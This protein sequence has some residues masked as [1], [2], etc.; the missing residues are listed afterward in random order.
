MIVALDGTPVGLSSGGLRRY[1]EE[2]LRALQAAFPMNQHKLLSDQLTAP[3]NLLE[4][5]WWSVGL[6]CALWRMGADVF[7]GTDFAVPYLPVCASVM[8]VH[9]LSPWL[10]PAWHSGAVRVRQRAPA[11]IRLGL[12]TM[13]L[14]PTEAIRRETMKTFRLHADRVAAVPH[15]VSEHFIPSPNPMR[16][17]V[18]WFLFAGTIEPR[19]NIPALLRAWQEVRKTA[20]VDLVLAGRRREDAPPIEPQPG[21]HLLGEVSDY[22]LPR[23]FSGAVA[24]VYPSHYEGFGLPVLEAMSCGAAVITSR[25]PALTEVSGGAAIHTDDAG[26][27][28]VMLRLLSDPGELQSRREQG[29][30]R[31][32]EF[33]WECTARRTTEVYA[34]AIR[35]FQFAA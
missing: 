17:E 12:A 7:H 18:P 19:K 35:R 9:D 22:E 2:L 14:T 13:V 11:L 33:T 20:V 30:R 4:R 8:T 31:A 21:L 32:R 24:L 26:L 28:S 16:L 5:R 1:T 10:D 6:P 15:G 23:L 34:E 25:D 27:A 29:R 3:G